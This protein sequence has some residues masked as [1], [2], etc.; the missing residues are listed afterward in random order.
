MKQ[1]AL[2]VVDMQNDFAHPKGS[3]YVEGGEK[4]VGE[5]N[6]RIEWYVKSGGVVV[7]TKDWHPERTVHFDDWP[8]HCVAR[9]WGAQFEDN[10][11][12]VVETSPACNSYERS[13]IFVKGLGDADAFSGF[14]GVRATDLGYEG[15]EFGIGLKTYLAEQ[16]VE[17]VTVVGLALDYCVKATA[18]DAKK[19]F[20][21]VKVGHSVAVDPEK[22]DEIYEEL[23]S[24]G[25]G[26]PIKCVDG[27]LI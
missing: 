27:T 8:V 23:R 14:D 4:L 21:T 18:L 24:A 5:I 1:T 10:L 11:L 25:I 26:C 9:S 13:A 22:T 16:G 20:H 7:Y 12:N 19:H 15:I 6:R 3:L 17:A 2:V